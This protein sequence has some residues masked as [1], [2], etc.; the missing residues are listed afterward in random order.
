MERETKSKNEVSELKGKG[1]EA[2]MKRKIGKWGKRQKGAETRSR[3][4]QLSIQGER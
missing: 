4:G 2:S 3:R 1:R